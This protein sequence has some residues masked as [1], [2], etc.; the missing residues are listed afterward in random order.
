M[1]K[2]K[3]QLLTEIMIKVKVGIVDY[4]ISKIMAIK[5]VG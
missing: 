3:I 2:I 4:N 1:S 5:G